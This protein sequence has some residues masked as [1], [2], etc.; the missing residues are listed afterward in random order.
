MIAIDSQQR[1]DRRGEG[2]ALTASLPRDPQ[3]VARLCR[4]VGSV[5]TAANVKHDDCLRPLQRSLATPLVEHPRAI[6][7]RVAGRLL[8]D[9]RVAMEQAT[10]GCDL[11]LTLP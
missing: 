11:P 4:R 3:V 8:I 7:H 2:D 9:H 10:A 6:L 5:E 1:F